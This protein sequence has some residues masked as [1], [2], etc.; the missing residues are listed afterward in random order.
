MDIVNKLSNLWFDVW[1]EKKINSGS[2]LYMKRA[3]QS[4]AITAFLNKIT[5]SELLEL[6][7]E[8]LEDLTDRNEHSL[9]SLI[10]YALL[11]DVESKIK[12][13][14]EYPNQFL[15]PAVV[16]YCLDTFWI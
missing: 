7:K 14:K 8:D 2:E 6:K 1:E 12:M 15:N 11:I 13:Y 3:L 5:Y 16:F 10:E 4:E 9:R